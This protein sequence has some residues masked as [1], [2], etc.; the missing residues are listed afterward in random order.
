MNLAQISKL[1]DRGQL[2]MASFL[3]VQPILRVADFKLEASTH[4]VT[5]EKSVHTGSAARAIGS[6]AQRDQ[7]SVNPVGRN[8]AAYER[9]ISIDDIYRY[10]KNVGMA[11]AGL[12][13]IVDR[14][15][16]ALASKIAS[17]VVADMFLGTD[18]DNRMLGIS[19]FV[20]DADAAGQT[21]KLGYTT[22]ELAAMNVQAALQLNTEDSQ[23][24]FV[25]LL[26]KELNNVP[27][28]NAIVVNPNLK[29]RINR[30]ARRI[31]AAGESRD[32]FGL[33]VDTFNGVPLIAVPTSAIPQTESDGANAD[34][35]SLYILRFEEDLGTSFSTNSGFKF[36]DFENSE[37]EP[38]GISR[39]GFYL[40]LTVEQQNSLRRVSRIRL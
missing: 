23:D 26:D 16:K 22:D 37:E 19:N 5:A 35:T 1:G 6:A 27:N 10:D 15:L 29:A 32:T 8:L 18:A 12:R 4:F 38:A 24:A 2:L 13:L 25:E 30:I 14:K 36:D 28:A 20:K 7:Q 11:S 40:N 39:L 34:C 33:P 17:E 31:G 3:N 21:A 9:E